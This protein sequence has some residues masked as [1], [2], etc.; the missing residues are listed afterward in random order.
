[1][2]ANEVKHPYVVMMGL[3]IGGFV[4]MLSETALN[5]ALPALMRDFNVT[6]GN[7]QWLVTSYLLMVGIVLPLTGILTKW[8]T[9]RQMVLFALADFLIGVI[10]SAVAPNFGVLLLGRIIQGIATGILLP[11]IFIVLLSIIKPNKRGSAMGIVG[12]VIMFAPALGP[13]LAGIILGISSWHF[14]FWMFVP[15]LLISAGL[16]ARSLVNVTEITKPKIDG[17]SVVLSTIGFGGLVVGASF[18]GDD[19]WL[20]PL[21]LASILVG[22]IALIIYVRRQT[23]LTIPILN[24]SVFKIRAYTHGLI[25]VLLDFVIIM[26]SAYLLPLYWQ[27]SLL[28]AVSLVGIFMLP[29]GLANAIFSSVAGRMSDEY[30][31]KGFIVAGFGLTTIGSVLLIL[32]G[33]SVAHWYIILAHVIIMIGVPLI[34]SPAQIFALNAI[35]GPA[36]ADASTILNTLQQ[37]VGALATAIATSLIGLGVMNAGHVKATLAFN[38]GAHYGFI[39]ITAIS[40]VGLVIAI[41]LPKQD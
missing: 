39:F 28:V 25:L 8:F 33:P 21:V 35:K 27:K 31:S 2:K 14:I 26:A 4:G 12:L 16:T 41:A 20:S 19:G 37:I 15:L 22:I 9:T 18:A 38:L 36:S 3:L 10:I 34:I 24:F 29:G 11:M 6:T 17:L 30:G 7:V 1:L 13:T 5:I 23:K 32:A 40:V